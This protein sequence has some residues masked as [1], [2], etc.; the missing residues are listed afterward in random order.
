[1]VERKFTSSK[2]QTFE[3]KNAAINDSNGCLQNRLGAVCQADKT[4][5]TWSFHEQKKHNVIELLVVKFTILT[6]TWGKSVIASHLEIGNI[7]ALTFLLKTGV[8]TLWNFYKYFKK[9]GLSC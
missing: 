2:Q 3:D 4:G 8:P 6:F 5:G 7:T 1:M 9:Y